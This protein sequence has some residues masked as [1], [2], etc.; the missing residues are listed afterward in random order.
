MSVTRPAESVIF[1][2]FQ[3]LSYSKH[4][5]RPS[6]SVD[7]NTRLRASRTSLRSCPFSSIT[8]KASP[9]ALKSCEK[10][11]PRLSTTSTPT[12]VPPVTACPSQESILTQPAPVQ[13]EVFEPPV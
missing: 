3:Q 7:R 1:V 10:V 2:G 11:L 9:L 13:L 12:T 5:L 6:A 8:R 4:V